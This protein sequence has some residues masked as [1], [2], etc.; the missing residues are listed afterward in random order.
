MDAQGR[1]RAENIDPAD[2]WVLNPQT[3]DYEL[4]LSPSAEQSAPQ[5]GVP[6][7]RRAAPRRGAARPADPQQGTPH[8]G[9]PRP[10]ARGPERPGGRGG[11]REQVPGQRRRRAAQPEAA[12][13]S[14][15]KG[16]TKKKST[17]KRILAWTGGTVAFVLVAA[18]VGGYLYYQH[19]NGNIT[20]VSDDGAGTGGFSKDR[21]IN[22]LLIGTDKRSGSGNKGYGDE[23]SVGHADTTL[24]LHVSK[25]RS[26]ATALSIP[27]DMITDIPDCPT[28]QDD[29]SMKTIPGSQKVRFNESLGQSER[30][31]SCVMRT[32]TEITGIKLDHFMV[33]D[34]NA[35]KTLSSAVDGVDVCLAKDIDDPKS[36]LKLPA[37]EH[38]IEGEDAL[39]FVRTRYTVGNGGDLSRIQLQQQFLSSLMRKLKSNDTLTNPKKMISLAEAGTKALTVDSKIADIMK[40]RDLGMELGKLDMKNLTFATA[41]VVDNPAEKK[42]VTVVLNKPKSDELFSMMRE[43]VSLTEVKK[44]EKK[45]KAAVAAR[46]KGPR[47]EAGDVRVDVYNGSE[48]NGAAQETLS[49][50][51]NTEGVTK[52][53]QLGNAGKQGKT[54]VEY[55]PGQADEARKLADLMGLP[56]AALK[57]G[58]SEK[59]AQGL[60]A[61]VLTLGADFKGAGTPIKAPSKAPDGIQK[62]EADKTVCAK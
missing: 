24:L 53:S 35:V 49:W 52:S 44:Q 40:L 18:G 1:G 58:K 33:A 17:G 54:T 27:R 8:E 34:F 55:G 19:L 28:E 4:R 29:G 43:D 20:S 38:S 56:A 14:R 22:I 15:R 12:A 2:Q 7:P 10:G 51:Q 26:N 57:P 61:M 9:A 6:G 41:P 16:K 25:D 60:P 31:P 37:G 59:N 39:A 23:G 5:T 45:E 62:V 42:P 32:V 50:L 48:R 3:G 21:A 36:H 47:A 13:G 11:G 46:L 30:T